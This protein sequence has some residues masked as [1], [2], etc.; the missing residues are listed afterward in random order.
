MACDI[1][2]IKTQAC[3]SGIGRVRDPIQLLQLIAQLTCEA[4]EAA[5]GGAVWGE[6]TG[7][8]SNQADLQSA[9][10]VK[11]TAADN[12][13]DVSNFVTARSNLGLRYFASGAAVSVV[14]ATGAYETLVSFTIPGG[15]MGTHGI[16][17]FN[18]VWTHTSNANSK[19]YRITYGGSTVAELNFFNQPQSYTIRTSLKNLGAQNSQVA[20][21]IGALGGYT[22]TSSVAFSTTA[23]DSS[24]SQSLLIQGQKTNGADVVTLRSAV[25]EVVYIA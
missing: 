16:M 22:S 7:T 20:S 9:L 4:S 3:T 19:G 21:S 10:D 17:F 24:A 14:G 15:S 6:I 11:L 2:T 25:V 23:V 5:G 8:L 13:S 12:L 1:N 18:T